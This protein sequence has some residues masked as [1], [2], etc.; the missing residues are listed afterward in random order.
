M[1]YTKQPKRHIYL[2]D[3]EWRALIKGINEYRKQVIDEN[4]CGCVEVV[5]ELLLKIVKAPTKRIRFMEV[6]K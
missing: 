5:N 4:G 3:F 2:D 6:S 1:I